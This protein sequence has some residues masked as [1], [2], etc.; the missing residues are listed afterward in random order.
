MQVWIAFS[1]RVVGHWFMR[2]MRAEAARMVQT[3]MSMVERSSRNLLQRGSLF[4]CSSHKVYKDYNTA[5]IYHIGEKKEQDMYAES[6]SI[7]RKLYAG[8]SSK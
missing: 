5:S 6:H 8:S 3:F 4:Y 2:A 7:Y 1:S